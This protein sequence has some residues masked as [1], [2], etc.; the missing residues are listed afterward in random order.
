MNK[1]QI[2]LYLGL[3]E[4]KLLNIINRQ[5]LSGITLWIMKNPIVLYYTVDLQ[6]SND[7][8]SYILR[9]QTV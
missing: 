5:E 1:D 8:I 4:I 2:Q 6:G 3:R 7:V 9:D